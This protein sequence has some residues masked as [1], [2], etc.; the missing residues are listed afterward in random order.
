MPRK[1][2]TS[3]AEINRPPGHP[4]ARLAGCTCPEVSNVWGRYPGHGYE[5]GEARWEIRYGCPLHFVSADRPYWTEG[6]A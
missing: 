6:A 3:V 4:D 1:K 2:A 5:D